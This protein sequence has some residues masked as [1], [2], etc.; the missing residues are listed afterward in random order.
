VIFITIEDETGTANLIVWPKVFE[1]Q[2]RLILSAR[3]IGVRGR[4][5]REGDVVHL[6]AREVFDLSGLL[7]SVG[8]REGPSCLFG[9]PAMRDAHRPAQLNAPEIKIAPRDFR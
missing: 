7:R 2:R 8:A 4:L 5:Q 9:G 1:R 3:L 6:I